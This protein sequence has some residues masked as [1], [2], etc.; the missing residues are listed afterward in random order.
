MENCKSCNLKNLR[1][2]SLLPNISKVFE[3]CLNN[4]I[5][6]FFENKNLMNDK[7][8]GFKYKHSTILAIHLLVSNIN[9]NLN[10][11]LSAGA[12]LKDF[13]K[14]FDKIWIPGLMYI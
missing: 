14:T 8:F 10:S 4:N 1:A 13:E 6:K 9:W 11:G 5:V 2:I 7:Q 12:F 3:V